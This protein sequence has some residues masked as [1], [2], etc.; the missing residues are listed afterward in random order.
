MKIASLGTIGLLIVLVGMAFVL[1]GCKS[2]DHK[3]PG[4]LMQAPQEGGR[5]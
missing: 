4:M 5:L 1:C 3:I 2:S